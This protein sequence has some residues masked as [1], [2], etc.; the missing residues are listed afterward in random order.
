M[1]C[2]NLKDPGGTAKRNMSK[3]QRFTAS[4]SSGHAVKRCFFE[5]FLAAVPPGSFRLSHFTYFQEA[6]MRTSYGTHEY[7][8]FKFSKKKFKKPGFS[9]SSDLNKKYKSA[10]EF[11]ELGHALNRFLCV[12]FSWCELLVYGWFIDSLWIVY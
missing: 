1:K 3:K 4:P 7:I 10:K 5:M 9:K 8:G 6:I 12:F 2:V 11:P